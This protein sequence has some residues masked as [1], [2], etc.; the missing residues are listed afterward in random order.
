MGRGKK[1]LRNQDTKKTVQKLFLESPFSI[2]WPKIPVEDEIII[3]NAIEKVISEHPEVKLIDKPA[4]GS[5]IVVTDPGR[6]MRSELVFGVNAVT[7]ATEKNDLVAVLV[8][9][10]V[11]PPQ[12]S[13][14]LVP[15]CA[16]RGIP[17][18]CLKEL[19][20]SVSKLFNIHSLVTL[21]LKTCVQKEE[22]IFRDVYELIKQKAPPVVLPFNQL[23][24]EIIPV[25]KMETDCSLL[26]K[27]ASEDP[28]K[29]KH[30]FNTSSAQ[31]D[32]VTPAFLPLSSNEDSALTFLTD[33]KWF[34]TCEVPPEVDNLSIRVISHGE[35]ENVL[36][37]EKG[38][39]Q[40]LEN[41]MNTAKKK[42]FFPT[43]LKYAVSSGKVKIKKKIKNK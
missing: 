9:N 20:T 5:R 11:K 12:L 28:E 34:F 15:L 39:E 35:I 40:C 21:G 18:I 29:T 23:Y 3:M 13:W 30:V 6:S 2:K 33:N 38:Q 1:R 10:A 17:V 22:S 14:H 4:Q 26:A 41:L 19:N 24:E 43:K 36:H 27:T 7:R 37:R 25:E 42:I 16:S 31:S 8:T 32:I